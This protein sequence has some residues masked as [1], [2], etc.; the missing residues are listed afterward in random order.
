MSFIAGLVAKHWKSALVLILLSGAGLYGWWEHH[1]AN[2]YHAQV[3][4]FRQAE[5]DATT[6]AKAAQ[7]AADAAAVRS[8]NETAADSARKAQA[9]LSAASAYKARIGMLTGALSAAEAA[10]TS[11]KAQGALCLDPAIR[12]AEGFKPSCP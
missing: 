5:R 8:A 4:S 7:A 3:I 10:S 11:A 6:Q 2:R 1:E 12:K 9:A